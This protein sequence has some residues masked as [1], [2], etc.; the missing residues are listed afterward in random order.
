MITYDVQG[1][2]TFR[3]LHRHQQKMDISRQ[4][5]RTRILN[6]NNQS[7]I[8]PA[9]IL[10]ETG[11]PNVSEPIVDFAKTGAKAFRTAALKVHEKT[12]LPANNVI[13]TY[14][15]LFM[16]VVGKLLDTVTIP[17]QFGKAQSSPQETALIH[18]AKIRYATNYN[19]SVHDSMVSQKKALDRIY[20]KKRFIEYDLEGIGNTVTEFAFLDMEV[21]RS[22]NPLM[23]C[24]ELT[25]KQLKSFAIL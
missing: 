25:K 8:L 15:H 22:N 10:D 1:M 19:K 3:L 14:Q 20:D 16:P 17:N 11:I 23:V 21:S 4:Q 18:N 5:A 24:A 13:N 9:N 12:P 2:S 7:D 6:D